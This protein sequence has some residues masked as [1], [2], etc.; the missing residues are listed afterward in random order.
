[1]KFVHRHNNL[2]LKLVSP[3]VYDLP[4]PSNISA[5]WNFGS[6]LGCCLGIQL[7]SGLFLVMH[8]SPVVELAF[9]SVS[10]IARDVNY[11]W[12][13][14]SVHANGASAFFACMF[15]HIGRG[16]YY[17]SYYLF[18]TWMVGVTILFLSMG[19]AFL[20]YVLPWG[21]MSFWGATVITNLVS[22]VPY[23][24]GWLVEW[25]WG[26][27][28][29]GDPTLKRFFM[30]HFLL[31]FV[32][33]GLVVLHIVFLHETGS[34]NPLGVG[35][36]C[37]KV[38]FHNYFVLKDLLGAVV[39]SM[40]LLGICFFSPDLFL[41]PVNFVPADPMKTPIHIQP[42]WYF[43]FAYTIL[44]SIPNKLGGVVALVMSIAVL[45]SMPFNPKSN[46]KG[47]SMYPVSQ[48]YFWVFVGSFIVLTYIGTCDVST[49]Y[50]EV[51]ITSSFIYFSFFVLN[52]FLLGLW[53]KVSMTSVN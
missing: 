32:L 27:F 53:D 25:I 22:A 36:E 18:H 29:V 7:V 51:G 44:R 19:I 35:A 45:Y 14:R 21:Q 33:A 37:D 40:V 31:P 34:S 30:L 41:D 38:P 24:G 9:S 46:F 1:M 43:L 11:G 4:V 6:L 13:I 28:S 12:L 3:V 52:P 49:P 48:V 8:Y 23:L 16:I 17:Q 15:I 20:G 47:L 10:H 39:L 5:F 50:V 26:G 42:E 2:F